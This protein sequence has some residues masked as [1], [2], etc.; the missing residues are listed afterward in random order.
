[1]SSP[2]E[3]PAYCPRRYLLDKILVD[4]A[5]AAGAELRQGHGG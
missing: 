3:S 5:V 1:M 4:G 2:L